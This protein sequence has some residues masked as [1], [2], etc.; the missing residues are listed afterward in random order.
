MFRCINK[1]ITLNE[2]FFKKNIIKYKRGN[3]KNF[4]GVYINFK[5]IKFEILFKREKKRFKRR[6]NFWFIWKYLGYDI[7]LFYKFLEEEII[8]EPE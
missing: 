5:W 1:N 2:D 3:K 8:L 6:N 4:L 7:S